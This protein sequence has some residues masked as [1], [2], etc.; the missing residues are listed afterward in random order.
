[1]G[2]VSDGS[3]AS[4]IGEIIVICAMQKSR[5]ATLASMLLR[6]PGW[7]V[8][9]SALPVVR[10][11]GLLRTSMGAGRARQ[12]NGSLLHAEWVTRPRIL[13]YP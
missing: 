2:H 10:V 7:G 6:W 4:A 11:S 9:H 12:G 3:A 8:S 13:Q 1:M 5:K